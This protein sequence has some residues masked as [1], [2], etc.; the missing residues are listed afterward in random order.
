MLGANYKGDGPGILRKIPEQAMDEIRKIFDVTGGTARF[1]KIETASR[2]KASEMELTFDEG[3][4]NE[5]FRH[6]YK[7]NNNTHTRQI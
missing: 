1:E 6:I 7:T 2:K 3:L 5:Y 4:D